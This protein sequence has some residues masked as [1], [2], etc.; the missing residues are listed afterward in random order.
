MLRLASYDVVFREVPGE[1]TL[2]LNLSGCPNR[3]PGC[4]SPHL[5][6]EAGEPLDEGLLEGLLATY[7]RAVTC[8]CF[9]GG[10]G[11]PEEVRRL[12]EE[13][14]RKSGLKTAWYSGRETLPAGCKPGAFDYIKLGPYRE[15]LG[16]LDRPESN[17]RFYRVEKGELIDRSDLFR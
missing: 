10:D 3:C 7:G 15:A 16:G 12:A 13:V 4:H 14:C 11:A 5:Q 6:T 9:M 17:Q 8:I 1:V 2:A